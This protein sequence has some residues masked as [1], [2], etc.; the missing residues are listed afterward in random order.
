MTIHLPCQA[1]VV[2]AVTSLAVVACGGTEDPVAELGYEGGV[3]TQWTDSTELFMEHPAL[4]VG[5]DGVFAVHLT[6][7]SDFAALAT[8][9]VTFR[10]T[11][12]DGGEPVVVVQEEPRAPGIFGPR[13][14]FPRA[15]IWDLQIEV[16]STELG[17]TLLVPGL[18]VFVDTASAQL[19]EVEADDGSISFL[20]EQ[21]WKTPGFLTAFAETGRV[22]E[23]REVPAMLVP[24][25]DRAARITAPIAGVLAAASGGLPVAGARVRE[26]QAMALLTPLLGEGGSALAAAR[27]ELAAAEQELGRAERLVAAEAAPARRV[28]EARIRLAAA[29]EALLAFGD[30]ITEDGRLAIRS[31]LAGTVSEASIIAGSRVAAGDHLATVVD[32]ERLWLEARIPADLTARVRRD[33]RVTF[34][35]TGERYRTRSLVAIAPSIDPDTR[36]VTGR[37][38]ADNADGALRPGA[39]AVALLPIEAVDSGVVIPTSAVLDDDGQPIAFVQVGG[40]SFERRVLTLGARGAH[41]VVVR[42]GIDAGERVVSGAANQ[43]RLASLSTAVPAHGHE[44]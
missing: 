39:L 27:A 41:H 40:E 23:V 37:W 36:T 17:D 2:L 34:R 44:H 22:Q 12:R 35:V 32:T 19:A 9:P 43:V 4:I 28:E 31:P 30:A 18:E 11:P 29:H 10:F 13:P 16:A 42:S 20:K 3:V 25:T 8:G 24:P 5:A 1:A 38:L 33:G 15:G 7:M 26:G 21:A 14:M 6:R